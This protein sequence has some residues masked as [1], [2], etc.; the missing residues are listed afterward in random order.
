MAE[1]FEDFSGKGYS[2]TRGY[3]SKNRDFVSTIMHDKSYTTFDEENR[4]QMTGVFQDSESI[5]DVMEYGEEFALEYY[6]KMAGFEDEEAASCFVTIV[7]KNDELLASDK[8]YA[9]THEKLINGRLKAKYTNAR[10]KKGYM[11]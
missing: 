7:E 11:N 10:K 9:H 3:M 4:M 5:K 1:L 6:S 2:N 8:L